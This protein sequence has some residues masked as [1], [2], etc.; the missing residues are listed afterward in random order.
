MNALRTSIAAAAL[1]AVSSLAIAS[2]AHAV[3]SYGRDVAKPIERADTARTA[4][5][6][7]LVE[8]PGRKGRLP[9]QDMPIVER[10]SDASTNADMLNVSGRA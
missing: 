6:K 2:D 3:Q 10:S 5:D 1:T 8:I 7:M 9:T 4:I